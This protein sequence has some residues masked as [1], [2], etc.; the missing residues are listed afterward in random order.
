[1]KPYE[2]TSHEYMYKDFAV[3]FAHFFKYMYQYTYNQT[4]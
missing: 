2:P 1:M 3:N 4:N